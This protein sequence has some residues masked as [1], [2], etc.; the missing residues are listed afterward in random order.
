MGLIIKKVYH[1]DH[2]DKQEMLSNSAIKRKA[3]RVDEDFGP[4]RL[5]L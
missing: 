3:Q 4:Q 2:F 1:V 5:R